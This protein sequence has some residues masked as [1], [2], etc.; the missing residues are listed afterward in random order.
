EHAE[1]LSDKGRL[2]LAK[3]EGASQRMSV[4]IE[5]VLAY[6]TVS[7]DIQSFERFSLNGVIEDI[8]NDLELAIIQKD[9]VI[10]AENLPKIFGI[11]ILIYQLFFNLISNSIKFTRSDA[12]PLITITWTK[13]KT[14]VNNKHGD[15]V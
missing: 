5:G 8:K 15:F 9:V 11:R 1:N 3:I 13:I 12:K 10:K 7:T 14:Q 4:M 2:Y 6:S